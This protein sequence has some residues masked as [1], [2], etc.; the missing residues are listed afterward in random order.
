MSLRPRICARPSART[1]AVVAVGVAMLGLTGC[2][3]ADPGAPGSSSSTTRAA[4]PSTTSPT[5]SRSSPTVSSPAPTGQSGQALAQLATL[6]VKGRAPKTGYS[7]GEF[8]QAWSDD[9]PVQFG[10][11]GCDTRNDIL[12]RDL[13]DVVA[14]PGT[15]DCVIASG[16]LHDPYT[17]KT[18]EFVRGSKTSTA[19]Q[20]DHV[21]PL[22]DA[23]QKGAQQ[24]TVEERTALAND[25]RNLQAVDGPTNQQKGAGDAA[26]W[27]PPQKS[28]RCTY[29]TRQIEVK[30]TYHL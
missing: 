23:W 5:G 19:V 18:I 29:V 8:G 28:Y 25:P 11:N 20:I 30:A 12:R 22:A 1:A 17:G 14:K 3:A 2:V 21:V 6:P 13:V 27:L 10:H 15:R 26:T 24:L 7:R 9:V 16:A 4:L